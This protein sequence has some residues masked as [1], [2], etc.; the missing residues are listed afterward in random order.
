VVFLL[1]NYANSYIF[2]KNQN[3]AYLHICEG[4]PDLANEKDNHLIGK[5]IG[6]LITDFMKANN[7][8]DG[9]INGIEVKF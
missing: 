8:T 2:R 9:I 4:A 6:Y 1:N 7:P 3:A 5:L